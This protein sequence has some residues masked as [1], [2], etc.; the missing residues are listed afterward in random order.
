MADVKNA[1][2]IRAVLDGHVLQMPFRGG[3]LDCGGDSQTWMLMLVMHDT[4]DQQWRIKPT[5]VVAAV[6]PALKPT[7]CVHCG[8]ELCNDLGW[9]NDYKAA[10]PAGVPAFDLSQPCAMSPGGQPLATMCMR[11]K[12]P[13]HKCDNGAPGDGG[14]TK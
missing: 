14:Q 13:H 11:C 6:D 7:D 5:D 12:N 2:L 8:K 10:G 4:R 1:E 9:C 3:W